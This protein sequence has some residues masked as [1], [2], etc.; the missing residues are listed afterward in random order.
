MPLG[1]QG[2]C[3]FLLDDMECTSVSRETWRD[4]R[5]SLLHK[6]ALIVY[7]QKKLQTVFSIS[8]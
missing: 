5:Q 7:H 4:D 3:W 8:K 6:N 1:L 2:Y